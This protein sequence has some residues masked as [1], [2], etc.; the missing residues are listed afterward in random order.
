MA[1]MNDMEDDSLSEFLNNSE[2]TDGVEDEEWS[3]TEIY[4]SVQLNNEIVITIPVE[5]EER[6]KVGIKNVKA[7]QAAKFK[8]DGLPIDPSVLSFS[9]TKS[10]EFENAVDLTITL[11]RKA[12]VPVLKVRIPESGL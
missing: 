8:E 9:S 3:Y 10:K 11:T 12:V 1:N 4:S 2:A 6:T 7:K 5:E